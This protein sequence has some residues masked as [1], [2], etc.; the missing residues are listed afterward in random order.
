MRINAWIRT[1]PYRSCRNCRGE[2]ASRISCLTYLR[3]SRRAPGREGTP[4]GYFVTDRAPAPGTLGG[5]DLVSGVAPGFDGGPV[6][7]RPGARSLPGCRGLESFRVQRDAAG[8]P[9]GIEVAFQAGYRPSVDDCVIGNHVRRA[10]GA[11][12]PVH[13]RGASAGLLAELELC[14]RARSQR[15]V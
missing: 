3:G 14:N 13:A 2:N 7:S 1:P 12:L 10:S 8:A 5:V 4:P 15:P 11:L 9:L 6:C